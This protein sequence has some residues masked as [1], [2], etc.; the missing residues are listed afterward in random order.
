MKDT[1]LPLASWLSRPEFKER[2]TD[3]EKPLHLLFY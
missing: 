3:P 1:M 2:Y